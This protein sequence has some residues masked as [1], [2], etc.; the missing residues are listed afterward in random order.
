[1]NF[2]SNEVIGSIF[3]APDTYQNVKGIGVGGFG[4]V[5]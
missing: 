5:W 4:L 3:L 1:L 2:Q